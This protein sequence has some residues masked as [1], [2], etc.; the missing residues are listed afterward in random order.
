[1]VV[2]YRD[3]NTG[4]ELSRETKK[5]PDVTVAPGQTAELPAF[6]MPNFLTM[7]DLELDSPQS[8]GDF[9]SRNQKPRYQLYYCKLCPAGTLTA[10]VPDYFSGKSASPMYRR[11]AGDWLR[12]SILLFFI[13]LMVIASR[14]FCRLFCPLGA[15]YALTA[16]VSMARMKLDETACI[17]CGICDKACPVGLDVRKEVGGMECIACGDCM[18]VCPK[19]GIRRQYGV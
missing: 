6:A 4:A 17:D 13:A 3:K 8:T 1:M 2:V 15:I 19:G 9:I 5:F 12:M 10:T 16:R 18:K 7:A 11:M 14:P